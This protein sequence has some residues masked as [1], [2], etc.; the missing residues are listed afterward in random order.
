MPQ[1]KPTT[2]SR[3]TSGE[4]NQIFH[5]TQYLPITRTIYRI[6][7]EPWNANHMDTQESYQIIPTFS[8]GCQ[9]PC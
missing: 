6:M 4:K 1:I 7:T 9:P 5:A 2:K 8:V 3:N